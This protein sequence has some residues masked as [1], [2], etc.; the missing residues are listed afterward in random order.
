MKMIHSIYM[1]IKYWCPFLIHFTPVILKHEHMYTVI[2][3]CK[4]TLD[5]CH[6]YVHYHVQ[7]YVTHTSEVL[8]VIDG[9]IRHTATLT[10]VVE[11][12]WLHEL[13]GLYTNTTT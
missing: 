6:T 13:H 3:P 10:Q 7:M 5:Y 8:D 9:G 12:L 2:H 11:L 1:Y 4:H